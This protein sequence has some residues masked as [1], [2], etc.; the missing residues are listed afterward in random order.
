MSRQ[1][2]GQLTSSTLE[3][4]ALLILTNDHKK[5]SDQTCKYVL[6][7]DLSY[8]KGC[9]QSLEITEGLLARLQAMQ[10]LSSKIGESPI[11]RA[12]V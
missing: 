9:G 10:L 8:E 7:P 12:V 11:Q 2:C 5:K 4:R 6:L 1:P 3:L